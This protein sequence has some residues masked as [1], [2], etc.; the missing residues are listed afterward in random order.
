MK[1]YEYGRIEKLNQGLEAAGIDAAMVAEIMAGGKEIRAG[2]TQQKKIAWMGEA[3]RRMDDLLDLDTRRAVRE[4]CACCLGG[5]RLKITRAIAKEY[6]TLEERIAAA[7]EAKYVFGQGVTV[8]ADGSLMVRF[9]PE[10]QESYR[11]VCLGKTQEPISETYCYCCGGH[12]KHHLQI[13][14][15]RP[16]NCETVSSALSSGGTRNC[17]FRYTYVD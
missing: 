14:L 1:Q 17:I 3:M 2:T 4:S 6:A 12:I 9:F 5:K 8:E 16:L 11:C 15:G 13:A 7:N 10:G